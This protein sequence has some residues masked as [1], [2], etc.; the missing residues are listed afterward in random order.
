V[1]I[2]PQH[3]CNHAESCPFIN[4]RHRCTAV[5]DACGARFGSARVERRFCAVKWNSTR[6]A[7]AFAGKTIYF[8]GDS[9][10]A[11]Q[12]RSLLCLEVAS[13]GR[14]DRKRAETAALANIPHGMVCVTLAQMVERNFVS[15]CPF[16]RRISRCASS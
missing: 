5:S 9:V 3:P 4:H 2:Y 7:S 1:A 11:Q 13:M 8:V 10:A 16:C 6:F 14:E 12:W 15:R